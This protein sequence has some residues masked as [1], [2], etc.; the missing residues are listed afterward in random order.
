MKYL[1]AIATLLV[2]VGCSKGTT[3]AAGAPEGSTTAVQPT[4]VWG[5]GGEM[6]LAFYNDRADPGATHPSFVIKSPDF[7]RSDEGVWEAQRVAATIYENQSETRLQAGSA[8]Y[9]Q[10]ARTATLTG[11]VSFERGVQH[12][13]LEDLVWVNDERLARTD[14][15]V[16]IAEPGR[17]LEA[18]KMEYHPDESRIVLYGMK[19]T[20]DLKP[21]ETK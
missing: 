2:V 13:D 15:P 8:R 14:K 11:G 12:A 17:V 5:G 1:V 4:G 16:R 9:D 21:E 6:T 7:Q 18:E 10:N 19:G 20:I 3:P